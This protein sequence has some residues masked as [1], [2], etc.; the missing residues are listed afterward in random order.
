MNTVIAEKTEH[1]KLLEILEAS[2]RA[3]LRR[4]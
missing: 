4:S 2:V 3:T 1:F